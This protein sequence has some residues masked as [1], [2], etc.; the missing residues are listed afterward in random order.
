MEVP[1]AIPL[2]P[3]GTGETKPADDAKKVQKPDKKKGLKKKRKRPRKEAPNKRAKGSGGKNKALK[4]AVGVAA[5]HVNPAN[6]KPVLT[7]VGQGHK[8]ARKKAVKK[9]QKKAPVASVAS[10]AQVAGKKKKRKP[11]KPRKAVGNGNLPVSGNAL[12]EKIVRE[13][14]SPHLDGP[15]KGN[16]GGALGEH[17]AAQFHPIDQKEAHDG[18]RQLEQEPEAEVG[19]EHVPVFSQVD[20][21]RLINWEHFALMYEEDCLTKEVNRA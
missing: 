9:N 12:T 3:S 19:E 15:R 4:P 13:E 6:H 7:D 21:E 10:V 20:K 16:D 5:V 1:A 8:K 18:D 2:F 14:S 17:G 11:A